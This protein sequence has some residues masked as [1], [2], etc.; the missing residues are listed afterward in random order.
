VSLEHALTINP[1]D[2]QV[3]RTLD[4]VKKTP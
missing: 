3:K 4:R 2:Q 1:N